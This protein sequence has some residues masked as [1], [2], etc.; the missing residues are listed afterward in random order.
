MLKKHG[1]I[2]YLIYLSILLN[3]IYTLQDNRVLENIKQH[4][5]ENSVD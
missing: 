3:Y 4:L 2:F 1:G 5:K